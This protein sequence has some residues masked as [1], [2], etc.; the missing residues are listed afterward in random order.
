MCMMVMELRTFKNCTRIFPIFNEGEQNLKF[1]GFYPNNVTVIQLIPNVKINWKLT[2]ST[3]VIFD[4]YYLCFV[5]GLSHV[6][7]VVSH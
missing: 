1:S 7:D 4:F 3:D 6:V 5:Y 2:K